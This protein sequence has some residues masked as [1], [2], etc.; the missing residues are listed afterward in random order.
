MTAPV[1]AD[2]LQ[3]VRDWCQVSPSSITDE[4]LAM[5]IGA[6]L[7]L[8]SAYT[9]SRPADAEYPAELEMALYRRSA[10]SMAA[11]GVPLGLVGGDSEFGATR[12]PGFDVEIERLEAPYRTIPVA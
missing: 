11:R 9:D 12:L 8:Q 10:R 5:V 6:E 4:Q 1:P 3:R 2:L 7:A